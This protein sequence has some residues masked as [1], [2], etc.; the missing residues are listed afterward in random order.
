MPWVLYY[1]EGDIGFGEDDVLRCF[2]EQYK[3]FRAM[4]EL[5]GFL[6]EDEREALREQAR[7]ASQIPNRGFAFTSYSEDGA[8][9]EGW[10]MF[11]NMEM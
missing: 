3:A 9:V 1:S 7:K 2:D 4:S 5:L 10:I 11:A 8:P 6:A